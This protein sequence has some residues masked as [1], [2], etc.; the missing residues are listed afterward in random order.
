M[1]YRLKGQ[2]YVFKVTIVCIFLTVLDISSC[3]NYCQLYQLT[4]KI[5]CNS[6]F[7]YFF[8]FQLF[9]FTVSITHQHLLLLSPCLLSNCI[10]C[11]SELLLSAYGIS[12]QVVLSARDMRLQYHVLAQA[13][14]D[15]YSC[16]LLLSLTCIC[17]PNKILVSGTPINY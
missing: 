11:S 4:L 9:S 3:T 12:Y 14:Y 15:L 17:Q 16:Q 1:G 7:S 5:S 8:G 2:A 13:L 6:C 10:S